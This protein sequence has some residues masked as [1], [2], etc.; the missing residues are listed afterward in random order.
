LVRK[1]NIGDVLAMPLEQRCVFQSRDRATQDVGRAAHR[2]TSRISASAWART[3]DLYATIG[4][5]RSRN[6]RRLGRSPSRPSREPE[7]GAALKRA[8]G[9]REAAEAGGPRG[10]RS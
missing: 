9:A 5:P 8:S 7:I 10:L 2:L 4:R 1:S 6:L 3:L